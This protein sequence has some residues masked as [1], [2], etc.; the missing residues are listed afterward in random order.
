MK[1]KIIFVLFA[2]A[3]VA[4]IIGGAACSHS[5]KESTL[6]SGQSVAYY[7]CPMH[8][9]VKSDKPGS[10]SICGMTLVPVYTNAPSAKP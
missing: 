1:L 10:C 4:L 2:V 7:T 3:A 5:S 8:P 9:S 6:A